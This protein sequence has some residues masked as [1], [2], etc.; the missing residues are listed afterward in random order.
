MTHYFTRNEN[1][2]N[3]YGQH[4]APRLPSRLFDAHVHLNLPAHIENVPEERWK[5]DWALECGHLL[6]VEHAYACAAELFPGVDYFITGFPLPAQEAD[7]RGNN[8]YLAEQHAKGAVVAFMS[9]RPEWTDEDVEEQ[10]LQGGFVGFKPYPDMVSGVK[11]AEISIYDYMPR[12]QWKILDRHKK[13]VMLHLPRRGRLADDDN[14]RELLEI[15]EDYP[16]VTVIIAHFG[17]SFNP[18]FLEEGLNKLDGAEGF[19]FDT[20]AVINPRVYDV[21]FDRIDH[22]R[23][24]YGSDMPIVFWHGRREWTE[25]AYINLSSEDYSWNTNRRDPEI[26]KTYTIYLYEEVRAILDGAEQNGLSR[27][28]QE[29]I[30][31]L[32]ATR[33]LGL[34]EGE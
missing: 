20:A 18:V 25:T 14:V 23:I 3:F 22:R 10:L 32:N 7:I 8:R 26:E 13:A 31:R 30:F 9:V 21:A 34:A 6:P 15:R 27:E 24:L 2:E 11:G 16:D 1:D 28:Q 17:R 33:A 12:R 5:N 19:Y 29:D 4:I